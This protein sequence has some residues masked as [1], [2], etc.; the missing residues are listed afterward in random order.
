MCIGASNISLVLLEKDNNNINILQTKTTPHEGNPRGAIM[1]MVDSTLLQSVDGVAVTGRKLKSKL[2]ASS[3]SEP[4]AVEH[5]FR[6]LRETCGDADVIVSAGGETFIAYKLDVGGRIINVFTGNKCASGTGEF[7]LQQI[8]RMNLSVEEAVSISDLDNPYKV[9]GRCSV[10][11]KSDCTHALNKGAPKERVTAGLCEMMAVK[12]LELLKKTEYK[13]VL[14]I[15]GASANTAMI[16]FLRKEVPEL[17]IPEEAK[18]FEALGAALWALDADTLPVDSPEDLFKKGESS[19]SY[20]PAI[21]DFSPK[22]TFKETFRREAKKGDVCIVGLDVGSTTTKAVVMRIAD[23]AILASCYLRTN[24]DPVGASRR[25]YREIHRQLKEDVQITGLGVT[26]SGRQI[27]GLH[28]LTPAVINEIIAHAT[29]AVYFDPLVDTIFEIGGQDAKYTYI[30]N[31]VAS[32]YAMNE[33]C[34]AGTGSFL[35]EAARESLFIST[36]EIGDIALTSERPLNF[37]DQCAAFI[38]SDIK[39][40]IQEGAEVRDLAAGL[41]YSICLNYINRVKGNR[42]VGRKVFMQGGVCYNKA[43]PAAMAA[44]TGK[45]IIVPPEPGLMGAFGVA[46]EVKNKLKLGLLEPVNFNLEELAERGVSYGEPFTCAGGKEKC[47][48]KCSINRIKILG[49][50]YP[51]GGAC[52]K[53]VNLIRDKK[54]LDIEKFD[55]VNLREKLIFQKFSVER[56]TRLLPLNS[57]TVAI[58]ISLLANTLFPLYYNFFTALGFDVLPGEEIDSEGMERR[59]AEFCYPVEISHGSLMGSIRKNPDIFFLPHVGSMPVENGIETSVT[60]PFVQAEPYYLKAAFGELKGK[61]VISPVLDFAG[62]YE[63]EQGS[64]VNIG[65]Q[66]G[67]NSKVVKEAYALAVQ[68]QKDFHAECKKIGKLFLDDLERHPE[69]TAVALFGR[70]YNAFTKKANMGIPQKFATRGYRVIPYD[71][72]PY[73]G[74]ETPEN[75]FWAQG[76]MILKA[77]QYVKRHRQLFPT[78]ITNFSC[79][80]D[81]FIVGFFRDIMGRK[82]SLTLELDSHSADAGLDTRVEAFLDVVKSYIEINK[83]QKV[84]DF[85]TFKPAEVVTENDK[86]WVTDSRG[87]RYPLNHPR[88]HVLMPSMGDLGS[89]LLAASLRHLGINTTAVP[90]PAAKELKIGKGYASCKECLPLILT[91]GSLFDYLENRENKEELLVYFM[92]TSSGPCRFGQYNILIKSLIEKMRIKDVAQISLTCENSYAG[93]GTGFTIRAWQ[94]VVISDVLEEIYSAILTIAKDKNKALGVFNEVCEKIINSVEKD[95]WKGLK[96]N[97]RE[98]A[99]TLKTVQTVRPLEQTPKVA[100]VG[101]IYVRRDGFSRQ[102]LVEKLADKGIMVRT[103]PIAEWVYY[104]DYLMKNNL[105]AG[106]GKKGFI[107]NFIEQFFKNSYERTIKKIF[108]RSGLYEAHMVDVEKIIGNVSGLI[109]PKLTV[110]TI[111]TAGAAI[112]EVVEEVAGVISIGPFGCMPSRIA[113]AIINAKMNETKMETAGDRDLVAKVMERYPSLPF[114]AVETDGNSFPQVIEARLEIFCLQV[115]R[116]HD[117]IQEVKTKGAYFRELEEENKEGRQGILEHLRT[118]R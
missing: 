67:F 19:F 33:A 113:E 3:I 117:R 89:K 36:E 104:C 53:Y 85:A 15:G 111:L 64:F 42:A 102:Y 98:A 34:S 81:S 28:A 62:G 87:E 29:A 72:L 80:P 6:S 25:C 115:K 109:S 77:A 82:P 63:R 1:G 5:A 26:G 74:E 48:R 8:K 83:D 4:E 114:L 9:A 35:E 103:A 96:E 75:M 24:G 41:V 10:F 97:L 22:V 23:D 99:R 50:I 100:L 78:Y 49:K 61:R 43:V 105:N 31:G 90:A 69:E 84:E 39:S 57:K 47:D 92:P 76:Q 68:A 51:F 91:V 17:Y 13:K 58:N 18:Y 44:L 52:N 56:A 71:F 40:A 108:S 54:E 95:D 70:P 20:L 73:E 60:C 27:A 107:G 79:G 30:T 12:V 65:R 59:G 55:L 112:T 7:F 101:E 37:S 14:V 116:V 21:K 16:N 110:E 2:N 94:S 66:L 88:V 86:T 46:L 106:N 93:L 11:C 118:A 32:D 45:D 38:S